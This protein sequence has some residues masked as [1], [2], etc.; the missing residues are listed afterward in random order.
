MEKLKEKYINEHSRFMDIDGIQ[1]HYRDEGEGFPL[2]LLHGAFSSLH[3]FDDWAH[4]LAKDYRI[5]RLDLPGFG[6]TGSTAA[7]DYTRDTYMSCLH[8]FLQNLGIEQCDIAG[9]SLGG[10]IAWEFVLEYPASIRKMILIG[11]AGYIERK[12]FPLPFKMAQTPFLNKLIKY[13]TPRNMVE[14]FL[15]EVYCDQ[16]KITDQIIDRYQDLFLMDGNRDAFIS[17]ANT[18]F[19]RNE[20][21]IKNIKSPALILWGAEDKWIPLEHAHRF[22][23]ELPNAEL[24]VYEEVGH[25]PMEEIPGQSARDVKAFLTK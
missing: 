24:I 22:K 21:D 9:S 23:N 12:D 3:T 14:R 19:E 4:A 8:T 6:L 18:K 20:E 16:T 13:I 10:W 11:S 5:I 7:T 25:I 1:V 17:I 2:L 15:K